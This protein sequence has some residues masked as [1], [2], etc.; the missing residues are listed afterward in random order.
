MIYLFL[1]ID[2]TGKGPYKSECVSSNFLHALHFEL[3]KGFL[4]CFHKIH[5]SQ[6]YVF[7]GIMGN[8]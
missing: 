4:L 2:D 6:G 5:A 8:Y 3:S 1:A 7:L